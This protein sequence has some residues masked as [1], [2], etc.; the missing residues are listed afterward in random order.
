MHAWIT[1]PYVVEVQ[2]TDGAQRSDSERA[3]SI[4]RS[5]LS[6]RVYAHVESL[7]QVTTSKRGVEKT[8]TTRVVIYFE[9]TKI[10]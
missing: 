2:C 3:V 9:S 5:A 8:V 4:Q 7:L 6:A 1:S 10:V